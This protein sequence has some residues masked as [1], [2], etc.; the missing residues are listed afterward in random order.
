ME[1]QKLS[2][3][4]FS[5][6]GQQVFKWKKFHCKRRTQPYAIYH[7]LYH[8]PSK[9]FCNDPSVFLH[10]RPFLTKISQ[11]PFSSPLE[12]NLTFS[13]EIRNRFRIWRENAVIKYFR[14]KLSLTGHKMDDEYFTRSSSSEN[15]SKARKGC[16]Q[17][18]KHLPSEI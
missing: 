16:T 9:F 17:I 14:R 8:H 1:T 4:F 13:A 18:H 11:L 12:P 10:I 6:S 3:N 2:G 5:T 15:C 7:W